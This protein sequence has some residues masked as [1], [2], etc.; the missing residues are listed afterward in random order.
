MQKTT[1]TDG[2]CRLS[3]SKYKTQQNKTNTTS[4]FNFN[5]YQFI[6]NITGKYLAHIKYVIK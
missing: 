6:E 1:Y 4:I 3:A 5:V 2:W